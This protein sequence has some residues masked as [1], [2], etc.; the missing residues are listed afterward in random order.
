MP[1]AVVRADGTGVKLQH[2]G[3]KGFCRLVGIAPDTAIH[4]D[5]RFRQSDPRTAANTAAD[6]RRYLLPGKKAC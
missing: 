3:S 5:A 2:P 4:L 6:Q 1:G